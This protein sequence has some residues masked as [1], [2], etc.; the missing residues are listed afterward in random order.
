MKFPFLVFVAI[1][2]LSVQWLQ[3]YRIEFTLSKFKPKAT[4]PK[5]RSYLPDAAKDGD[6]ERII[7]LLKDGYPVDLASN[8]G[9]TA[10]GYAAQRGHLRTVRL[11]LD[12]G[13]NVNLKNYFGS[14]P[15]LLAVCNNQDLAMVKYLM[16]RGA[17]LKDRD[18]LGT[19]PLMCASEHGNVSV[20]KFLLDKNAE[21]N[22]RNRVGQTALFYAAR[23]GKFL[24]VKLL[25]QN[26][27]NRF[28]QDLF[29]DTAVKKAAQNHN[30]KL[31]D[32]LTPFKKKAP[33]RFI[34]QKENA[35]KRAPLKRWLARG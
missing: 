32:L 12:S 18:D 23:E 7:A 11:L 15:L 9:T 35:K 1:G 31:V 19:T 3:N 6:D 27:A 26:G 25:L 4:A 24:T 10:L 29:G 5:D 30:R 28:I 16:Q 8:V 2:L 14:T 17:Q 22:A 33:S 34:A 13:S 20:V 21:I